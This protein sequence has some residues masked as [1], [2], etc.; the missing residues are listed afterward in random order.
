MQCSLW[1]HFPPA[2]SRNNSHTG[3]EILVL[4]LLVLSCLVLWTAIELY[5]YDVMYETSLISF[6]VQYI[7]TV[8]D[9]ELSVV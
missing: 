7:V 2:T 6:M 1:Y 5:V 3:Q 8:F 9:Q 4:P